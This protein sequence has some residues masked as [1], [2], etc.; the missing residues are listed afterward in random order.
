MSSKVV[1]IEDVALLAQTSPS[2]VSNVLNGRLDRMRPET[3]DRIERAM[4][5]LGYTPNQLARQLKTG[6]V[7][8]LEIL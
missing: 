6:Q 4:T 7:P 2:T 8:I 5:Q 3:R 1:T